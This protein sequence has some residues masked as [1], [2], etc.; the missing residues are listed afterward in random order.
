MAFNIRTPVL[1]LTLIRNHYV[2][3]FKSTVDIGVMSKT[4]FIWQ[5]VEFTFSIATAT[6]MCLK[7]LVHE[8]N[9]SFSL[10]GD[11]IRTHD[12]TGYITSNGGTGS[13]TS[14]GLANR[15]GGLRSYGALSQF[16]KKGSVL[17]LNSRDLTT[18]A[19]DV[20]VVVTERSTL[21]LSEPTRDRTG[22][23]QQ[24]RRRHWTTGG[25]SRFR[26]KAVA[27]GPTISL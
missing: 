11:M 19:K 4:V 24:P 8:F 12:A 22:T 23:R 18:S 17:E 1:A 20:Q 7:P 25:A 10:R 26:M 13:G 6:L 9:T 2:Y 3:L 16:Y 14:E 15:M 21:D 5:E 27:E